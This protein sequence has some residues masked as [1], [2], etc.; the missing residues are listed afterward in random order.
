MNYAKEI[1]ELK[2]RVER[3]ENREKIT[4]EEFW[5]SGKKLAIYCET[6]EQAEKLCKAFDG[7]GKKWNSGDSYLSDFSNK[8]LINAKYYYTNNRT[9]DDRKE[10]EKD[11]KIYNFEDVIFPEEPKSKWSFTEDEKVILRNISKEYEWI[12]RDDSWNL[13][14]Y[15][16]KPIKYTYI[17]VSST[18][19]DD[20]NNIN[21]FCHLFQCISWEDDE[22]CEFRRYL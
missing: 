1:K 3:L 8:Y 17:W 19:Y 6:K 13:Y 22:P 2:A 12:A 20:C 21:E 11:F 9:W 16:K 18:D 4:L 15:K 5:D 7:M 10:V 14:I